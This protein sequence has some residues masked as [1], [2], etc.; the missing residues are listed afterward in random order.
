MS[1]I[2]S[3]VTGVDKLESD[4]LFKVVGERLMTIMEDWAKW[5]IIGK[6][7]FQYFR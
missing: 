3:M 2:E 7:I 5:H 6:V 1:N 4:Y